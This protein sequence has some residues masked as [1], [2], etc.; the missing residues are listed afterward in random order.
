MRDSVPMWARF[1]VA[2]WW[3]L[4]LVSAGLTAAVLAAVAGL[5]FPHLFVITGRL[6][7]LL[8]VAGF[9]AIVAALGVFA[10]HPVRQA[11]AAAVTGLNLEQRT[12]ISK[13]LRRG[14]VPSD[15]RVLAAAIRVGTL[16]LAY[17]RRVGPWQKVVGW[18]APALFI[19]AA[20]L[21]FMGDAVRQGVFSVGLA[22]LL[23]AYLA[24]FWYR[25]RRLPKHVESLRAVA[26]SRPEAA[27][28]PPATEDSVALPSRRL[29]VLVPSLIVI[30]IGAG[31]AGYLSD[32]PRPDC[33][34]ADAVVDFN[35]KHDDMI[36]APVGSSNDLD[37]T[38]YRDWSNQLQK[39]ARQVSSPDIARHLHRIADLSAQAVS[40]V[41]DIRS[42]PAAGPSNDAILKHKSAYQNTI[43]Q[44]LDVSICHP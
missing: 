26:V 21:A 11:Y 32:R 5:L 43:T 19:V 3:V 42:D 12:Q 29:W 40:L 25:M 34:T 16:N 8:G 18:L 33:R 23:A 15:P 39:Y 41:Q 44:L 4:W 14:E 17:L 37:L 9:S 38:R 31:T 36:A 28:L 6:W 1:V 10:Q 2:P 13:A 30:G 24:W 22:L 7:G 27:A 20:V 35:V